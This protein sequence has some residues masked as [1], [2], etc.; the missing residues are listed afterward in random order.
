MALLPIVTTKS[1]GKGVLHQPTSKVRDFGTGLHKL[2]DDMLETLRD[3]PGVGL[4]A[5]QVGIPQRIAIVEYP[6]DEEKP[7]ETMRLY[8]LINP[9]IIKAKG[10]E[11]GQEGC[12]SMPGL[13][14]DVKRATYVVVKAQDRNGKEVRLKAYDWLARIF[15]HEIDHL[16]GVLMTDKAD[17]VYRVVENEKGEAELIPLDK[18]MPVV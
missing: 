11:L 9:E 7:E 1:P 10:E 12:L 3:A 13:A 17:V 6:D 5:P 14:A 15:Q 8:E 2:L 16:Q 18:A 4:A